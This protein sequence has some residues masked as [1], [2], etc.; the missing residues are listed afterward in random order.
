MD[1][2]IRTI[3]TVPD[4]PDRPGGEVHAARLRCPTLEVEVW[5]LGATLVDLVHRADGVAIGMVAALS[6]LDAYDDPA[7]NHFVGSTMGRWCRNVAHPGIEIDGRPYQLTANARGAHPHGGPAGFHLQPWSLRVEDN[8]GASRSAILELVSPDGHQGYPGKVEARVEYRLDL[9]G[10]L[11][12]GYRARTSAA[13]L[14]GLANHVYWRVG[15]EPLAEHEVRLPASRR[16]DIVDGVPTADSPVP[17]A[18]TLHDLSIRRPVSDLAID[19]Y[20]IFDDPGAACEI[21]APGHGVTLRLTSGSPG[22]GVYTGD[23]DPTP[24]RGI[25]LEFGGWPGAERRR[26]F[27]SPIVR[28]GQLYAEHWSLRVTRP[29]QPVSGPQIL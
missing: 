17:V 22:V 12:V 5:S 8:S 16:L 29:A 11:T 13:T 24:R 14:L 7:R 18:G 26:D 23:H 2:D 20:Y 4:R 19:A 9:D 25:C 27:P 21:H 3:G 10:T 15:D 28:P 1:H 6:S